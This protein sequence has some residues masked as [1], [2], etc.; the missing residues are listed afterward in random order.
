[1]PG[2]RAC[3]NT[4]FYCGL[5][6]LQ[7]P[8]DQRTR[9]AFERV[10]LL[11]LSKALCCSREFLLH[12]LVLE[13]TVSN[14]RHVAVPALQTLS[15]GSPKYEISLHKSQQILCLLQLK[16]PLQEKLIQLEQSMF[17]PSH[18]VVKTAK[19]PPCGGG[20]E[21]GLVPQSPASIIF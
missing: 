13:D 2:L 14:P 9:A 4:L 21:G 11:P 12:T 7:S 1:M 3:R 8:R 17:L 6:A 19:I 10:E 20:G 15:K 16:V 18:E 5:R